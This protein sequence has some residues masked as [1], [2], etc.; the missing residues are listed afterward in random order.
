[1]HAGRNRATVSSKSGLAKFYRNL[2]RIVQVEVHL[3]GVGVGEGPDL[4]VDDHEAS[5]AA[6]KE[7]QVHPVPLTAHAQ[8]PLPAHEAEVI[9]QFQEE[10]LQVLDK[11]LFQVAL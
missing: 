7:Q 4:Q 3:S 2:A 5:Q 8:P 11:R 6:V 1:M 10:G 9:S